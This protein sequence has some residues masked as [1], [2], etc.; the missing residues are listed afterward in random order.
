MSAEFA[1]PPR[2]CEDSRDDWLDEW[3]RHELERGA[4]VG[5]SPSLGGHER[6]NV[7]SWVCR[8]IDRL[9]AERLDFLKPRQC[10]GVEFLEPCDIASR[11]AR[12]RFS[13]YLREYLAIRVW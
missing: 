11:I 1:S 8:R 2:L 5:R 3:T 7:A 4:E 10:V 13:S 6:R 9:S 12:L